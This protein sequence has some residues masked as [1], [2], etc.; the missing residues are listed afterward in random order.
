MS[1][2]LDEA[3]DLVQCK[4]CPWYKSCVMPLRFDAEDLKRQ[5]PSGM[6]AGL[7]SEDLLA[8]IASAAQQMLLEG[9]PIFVKRLRTSSRL[10]ERL[11]KIMQGWGSEEG[12]PSS[13][14]L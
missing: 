10:A 14:S 13:P 2:I 4:E 11:K 9:C 12:E 7:P 3:T 8:V 5:M 1:D 6:Q